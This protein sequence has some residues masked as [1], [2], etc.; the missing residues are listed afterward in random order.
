MAAVLVF[1]NIKSAEN[2]LLNANI[3]ALAGID[4]FYF[5][6]SKTLDGPGPAIP[7]VTF[8]DGLN[9]CYDV[10]DNHNGVTYCYDPG[11]GGNNR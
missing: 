8:G 6:V 7:W 2:E 11:D 5:T 3:E 10:C 1:V 9:T 4:P